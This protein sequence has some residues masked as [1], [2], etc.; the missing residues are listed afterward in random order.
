MPSA[1]TQ[2]FYHAVFSTRHRANL[3]FPELETRLYPFIGGI[4]RDLRSTLLA[5]NGMSDHI[6]ALVRYRVDLSHSDMI[7]HIKGRTSNSS[8]VPGFIH[9][10]RRTHRPPQ[11]I[12]CRYDSQERLTLVHNRKTRDVLGEH[13]LGGCDDGVVGTD[14]NQFP[15]HDLMHAALERVEILRAL[16]AQVADK[17]ADFLENVPI[18]DDAMNPAAHEN[19]GMVKVLVVKQ[20]FDGMNR[21]VQID[22]VH[23][24]RHN[25]PHQLRALICRRW[26]HV[27]VL[28]VL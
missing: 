22:R 25:I 9:R 15:R 2:N 23:F 1:Y 10:A 26:R 19:N 20:R 6:H 17:R 12:S 28:W 4:L 13:L 27:N 14:R 7:R 24:G 21:V 18:R 16:H 5:I 8:G 11:H 3:I